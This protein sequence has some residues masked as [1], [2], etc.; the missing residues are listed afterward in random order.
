MVGL[1]GKTALVTGASRGIGA[2]KVMGTATRRQDGS[3]ATAC[4]AKK[5]ATD[6]GDDDG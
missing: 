5:G 1:S 2:A 3:A 4:A 6:Q